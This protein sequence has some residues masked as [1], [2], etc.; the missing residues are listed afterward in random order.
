MN[1]KW[2]KKSSSMQE[3]LLIPMTAVLLFQAL[4][5][6]SAIIWGGTIEQLTTNSFEILNERVINRKN[7]L[8]NQMI[9]HWSN[10]DSFQHEV[11][12]QVE[13]TLN[14]HG[15]SYESLNPGSPYATQILNDILTDMMYMIRINNLNG[16]FV[17]FNGANGEKN[18]ENKY[19]GLH[20]RNLDQDRVSMDSTDFLVEHAPSELTKTMN[21]PLDTFWDPVFE[22]QKASHDDF[23]YKPYLAALGQEIYDYKDYGYWCL[24]HRMNP[25]DIEVM[26]YSVPLVGNDGIVY[27]VMGVEIKVD[28]LQKILPYTEINS[29][30]S[31]G[32]FIGVCSANDQT[33]Q[34]AA[35]SGPVIKQLFGEAEQVVLEETPAHQSTYLFQGIKDE[36]DKA[37]GCIQNIDLYNTNTPFE[38]EQWA[39]I[40]IERQ[41]QLHAVPANVRTIILL[42]LIVSLALGFICII[43][44][45]AWVTHPITEL[46]QKLKGSNSQK[47]IALEGIGMTEIDELSSAIQMLSRNVADNAS[48]LSRIISMADVNLG[49]FEYDKATKKTYCSGS[50]FRLL[51]LEVCETG[52]VETEIFTQRLAQ[53]EEKLEE[54]ATDGVRIYK[55]E[56]DG[57]MPYWVRLK[58]SEDDARVFGVVVDITHEMMEKLKVEYERDYD[59]LTNLLNRRAFQSAIEK[60][61][62]S[63]EKLK[64]AALIMLDLDNLKFINDTYG[65]D[66]GDLYIRSAADS[67]R[68]VDDPNAIISRRSGDEFLMFLSGYDSKEEVRRVILTVKEGIRSSSMLLPNQQLYSLRASA[69]VSWYPDDSTNYEDLLKYAD[70]AMYRVKNTTKG[71]FTEFNAESYEKNSYLLH[72]K[73]ELNKLIDGQLVEYHFQPIVSVE[74]GSIYAYEALLRSKLETLKS[75]L[76]ILSLAKSQSMLYKIERLTWF[77]AMKSYVEKIGQFGLENV[78]INSIPSESLS[79]RDLI[80]FEER[81]APYLSRIVLE[82]TEEERSNDIYTDAKKKRIAQWGGGIALDD[83][84]SGYNGETSLLT[85]GPDFV[86]LDMAL[87]RG[88]DQDE[89]RQRLLKNLINYARIENIKTIAEGVETVAEMETLISLGV[90][91]L[92][93]Y[94]LGK[95]CKEPPKIAPEMI[96]LVCSFYQKY[97]ANSN[98]L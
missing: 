81:F 61:F 74:D 60:K 86:K 44:S 46:V 98:T 83:F 77:I 89:G 82:L 37:Y 41:A 45:T 84:G 9:Q 73:G 75:P 49:A 34:K 40:G 62:R 63:P 2:K 95:P 39:L 32:F 12:Q 66:Y 47:P 92:Q 97:H 56:E 7:T 17:I 65:H 26:T 6:Y 55:V 69:G 91:Y 96:E 52:Y 80:D 28:Y 22:F 23:Y 59:I 21:I 19:A 4:L 36:N 18:E 64:V 38:N 57:E 29:E 33:F 43:V 51:H 1:W 16:A 79:E 30:R 35:A 72:G 76:E 50:M 42:A 94:L 13:K 90:D 93:G 78:F 8:E 31:G 53:L 27:G 25:D 3:S 87:V 85:L 11:N 20:L 14:A 15:Q 48:K 67:L 10:V 24:P 5:F 54:T 70:F 88:V 58:V 68:K 71:E